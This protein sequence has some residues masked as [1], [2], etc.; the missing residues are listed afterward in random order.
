MSQE[1]EDKAS[2]K[3]TEF[4]KRHG[5]K[6]E[7]YSTYALNAVTYKHDHSKIIVV[8]ANQVPRGVRE[9]SYES[10]RGAN[11]EKENTRR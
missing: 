6:R 7:F 10:Y 2:Q 1:E 4:I 3:Y 11:V 5:I 9:I 8:F